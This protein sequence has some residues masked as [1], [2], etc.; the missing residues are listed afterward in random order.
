[1]K[2]S[3]LLNILKDS[4]TP[5]QKKWKKL[6]QFFEALSEKDTIDVNEL[7]A[8]VELFSLQRTSAAL[9][10]VVENGIRELGLQAGNGRVLLRRLLS[11]TAM[12]DFQEK[13]RQ[14]HAQDRWMSI[15]V[16][17]GLRFISTTEQE[18]SEHTFLSV[19]HS[20][21]MLFTALFDGIERTILNPQR[22]VHSRHTQIDEKEEV[23][24]KC[25]R[26]FKQLLL[27]TN[28]RNSCQTICVSRL[29][30][31][32]SESK[33]LAE[34][35]FNLIMDVITLIPVEKP[36]F[37]AYG[38]YLIRS[39][40]DWFIVMEE[41]Y[42]WESVKVERLILTILSVVAEGEINTGITLCLLQPQL[43]ALFESSDLKLDVLLRHLFYLAVLY[44]EIEDKTPW[45]SL[46]KHIVDYCE[47]VGWDGFS[48]IPL[49]ALIHPL[50]MLCASPLDCSIAKPLLTRIIGLTKSVQSTNN[51][52]FSCETVGSTLPWLSY[53]WSFGQIL[54]KMWMS[55]DSKDVVK[56]LTRAATN[57]E[58]SKVNVDGTLEKYRTDCYTKTEVI[59]LLTCF[60]NCKSSDVVSVCCA[61]LK[62]FVAIFSDQFYFL[63]PMLLNHI[64]A[65]DAKT[66]M[67][68]LLT[69][70]HI[71][72]DHCKMIFRFIARNFVMREGRLAT[73]G[74]VMLKKLF[75]INPH[76]CPFEDLVSILKGVSSTSSSELRLTKALVVLQ[77]CD[78]GPKEYGT[79]LLSIIE[80]GIGDPDERVSSIYIEALCTLCR[81]QSVDFW[82]TCKSVGKR[83]LSHNVGPAAAKVM[84]FF[85]MAAQDI[86]HPQCIDIIDVLS[87]Q[88]SSESPEVRRAVLKTFAIFLRKEFTEVHDLEGQEGAVYEI[89]RNDASQ[90]LLAQMF[91]GE[92][93]FKVRLVLEEVIRAYHRR[94]LKNDGDIRKTNSSLKHAKNL[95]L[96]P[97]ASKAISVA[98]LL[99][100]HF[101][102]A[103]WNEVEEVSPALAE[104]YLMSSKR[105]GVSSMED[106]WLGIKYCD[107]MNSWSGALAMKEFLYA[108]LEWFEKD[109]KLSSTKEKRTKYHKAQTNVTPSALD[110]QMRDRLDKLLESAKARTQLIC[111]GI[112]TGW[113]GEHLET[114]GYWSSILLRA[115]NTSACS[116]NEFVFYSLALSSRR[117]TRKHILALLVNQL[118][119]GEQHTSVGW[120]IGYPLAWLLHSEDMENI[121][122]YVLRTLV[123]LAL[124][125][126]LKKSDGCFDPFSPNFLKNVG[127][128]KEKP[129]ISSG[130]LFQGIATCLCG[131]K[132]HAACTYNVWKISKVLLERL[133][134]ADK[135][136]LEGISS[137]VSITSLD[138]F[139]SDII[140]GSEAIT[141]L[142]LIPRYSTA[143]G[144]LLVGLSA[145]GNSLAREQLKADLEQFSSLEELD[146]CTTFSAIQFL[147]VMLGVDL[148]NPS[149]IWFDPPYTGQ[150]EN[151]AMM[152][153]A[154]NTLL[155]TIEDKDAAKR[156]AC[157]RVL[158]MFAA[159]SHTSCARRK[160]SLKYTIKKTNFLLFSIANTMS[161]S[162]PDD[163][164]L[165]SAARI[166]K[167]F[168]K[169]PS[170]NFSGGSLGQEVARWHR[171]GNYSKETRHALIQLLISQVRLDPTCVSTLA[172]L[173]MRRLS[174]LERKSQV[175]LLESLEEI[176]PAM[177]TGLAI[178]CIRTVLT[179]VSQDN[180]RELLHCALQQLPSLLKSDVLPKAV[181]TWL[182][183]YLLSENF[184][185]LG[186]SWETST[187]EMVSRNF[188]QIDYKLS[189]R[190]SILATYIIAVRH[191]RDARDKVLEQIVSQFVQDE[192]NLR[193]ALP[194]L[195]LAISR[196]GMQSA[197]NQSKW[198]TN[199]L[200]FMKNAK[201]VECHDILLHLFVRVIRRWTSPV[202]ASLYDDFDD[203]SISKQQAGIALD[204]YFD[205]S[206]K[207][208]YQSHA[209]LLDSVIPSI[210]GLCKKQK[211]SPLLGFLRL[212]KTNLVEKKLW[213]SL[214]SI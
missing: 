170:G 117:K 58:G 126:I 182:E 202:S 83:L 79:T 25:A 47:E 184:W 67:D 125:L 201:S 53:M 34:V 38:V 75:T 141:S 165:G 192:G 189:F 198:V 12:K 203:L 135:S 109:T 94:R 187:W 114:S 11:V 211:D 213:R 84:E 51:S 134:S 113:V 72:K 172:S 199:L 157:Y 89:F 119:K 171:S 40:V 14:A 128:I 9:W 108:G 185:S 131:L 69:I 82:T 179:N 152:G 22:S 130:N 35:V 30:S 6:K 156:D 110:R 204:S 99:G 42:P 26:F 24:L 174:T 158:G 200:K 19:V 74:L 150:P 194:V 76:N 196:A 161:I 66:K 29:L 143:Y 188:D 118:S 62:K 180:D 7:A 177:E 149:I 178:K 73:V 142:E 86:D 121:K 164:L 155:A 68:L 146:Y 8:L 56:W 88:I 93:N 212:R 17:L 85:S 107:L 44:Y 31:I 92:Q 138:L 28:I 64:K 167:G 163:T 144:T 210:V 61:I 145:E 4:K 60:L 91:L 105:R 33:A 77:I 63:L 39:T 37:H 55:N 137:T 101:Q 208:G 87:E 2:F 206:Y 195:V 205:A 124:G 95:L 175:L 123:R 173:L 207:R 50:R 133:S 148:D 23:F 160:A 52:V 1:M 127:E 191:S 16:D 80:I 122:A 78:I 176:T 41:V 18:S 111:R 129:N 147:G 97:Y 104:A 197:L 153:S 162:R 48:K 32:G 20:A 116:G 71:G 140:T 112:Y 190:H 139:A 59:V 70:P 100:K 65:S 132:K 169:F 159:A 49:L 186:A 5:P 181:K 27:D 57:M 214:I 10:D 154:L 193:D 90:V 120:G 45:V 36:E 136:I 115:E 98:K 81:S 21:P 102:K 168:S 209:F 54:E 43:S 103:A 3:K 151:F 46:V 183:E 13:T 15:V 106:F 96:T 166:F